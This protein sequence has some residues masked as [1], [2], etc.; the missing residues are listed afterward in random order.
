MNASR[1]RFIAR[2]RLGGRGALVE[3]LGSR[4]GLRVALEIA[5]RRARAL[6]ERGELRGGR[7]AARTRPREARERL[8]I[9]DAARRLAAQ[10]LLERVG[11]D[12]PLV[13]GDLV[14][15]AADVRRVDHA[16]VAHERMVGA[17]RLDRERVERRAREVAGVERRQRARPRRSAP[18]ARC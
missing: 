3:L 17:G 14:G 16:A 18:R 11:D 6:G 8:G 9:Q 15:V 1:I 7:R 4:L 10:Q 2:D 5:H 13:R 12:P